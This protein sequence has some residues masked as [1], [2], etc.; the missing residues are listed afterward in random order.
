MFAFRQNLS[1]PPSNASA[2]ARF[3]N[4]KI[5]FHS[6]SDIDLAFQEVDTLV[7]HSSY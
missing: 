3:S 5:L 4:E 7:F 6:N 1:F 2:R